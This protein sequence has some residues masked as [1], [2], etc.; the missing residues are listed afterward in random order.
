MV[1]R[2]ALRNLDL[3]L[4]LLP[5]L[6]YFVVFHYLPMYGVLLAFKDY[7]PVKGIWG[8]EWVGL[9]HFR[10]FFDSYYF[11][12][13]IRNTL[14]ISLYS[15]VVNFPLPILFALMLNE[16]R[17]M[18]FRKLLQTVTYAPHFISVVVL[19]GM[20]TLFLSPQSGIV[21]RIVA[22]FGGQSV[23]FLTEPG[24]FKTLYVFSGV[25]QEL[26]WWSIIYLAALAGIDPQLHEAAKID[27]AS[28]LRRIWHINLPGIR[29]VMIVLLILSTGSL[30]SVGF[31]KIFLLQN[32]L[33]LEASEVIATNVYKIGL[34]QAQYS[35]STAVNLF[36]SVINCVLLL[37]VNQ[38]ARRINQTS[39]W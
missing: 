7:D 38:L 11:G 16:V 34:A 31:E 24:W 18:K 28:V 22:A 2:R 19:A 20:L 4:L 21:N 15:L 5:A 6:T 29:P 9:A 32:P 8:S 39:L 13:I 14:G 17:S 27:G 3:Y 12:T 30:M 26:G 37:A 36:N 25:W 33:N 23:S 10:R 1:N 35:Y